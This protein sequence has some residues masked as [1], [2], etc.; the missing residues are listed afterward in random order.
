MIPELHPAGTAV[1][2]LSRP[3]HAV[4]ARAHPLGEGG[5]ALQG[6]RRAGRLAVEV[7][8]GSRRPDSPEQCRAARIAGRGGAVRVV[9]EPWSY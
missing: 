2:D 7:D 6:G 8:A 5:L 9:K 1:E 3:D 4:S